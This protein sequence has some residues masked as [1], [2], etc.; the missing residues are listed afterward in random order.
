MAAWFETTWQAVGMA[1][2]S[3][4]FVYV[5]LIVLTRVA[6]L[7]SFSKMSSFDFAM[8]VALGSLF[9]STIASPDPPALR[10]AAAFA[11]LFL[12]Q[13]IIARLRQWAPINRL[14]DNQPQLLMYQGRVLDDQLR[15]CRV[16]ESD[17]RAKLREANVLHDGQVRA[18]VFES[19]GDISVL[20]AGDD[21]PLD[22]GILEGVG[23]VP[24]S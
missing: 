9:A 24:N 7:R 3:V 13:V 15:K 21:T 16:T 22:P 17:L 10:S 20:H 5:L 4:A 23:G 19:T 1:T 2:L 14:I 18:V 6:G 8:T 11:A 12:G